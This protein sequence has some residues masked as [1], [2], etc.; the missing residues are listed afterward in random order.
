M[1][2]KNAALPIVFSDDQPV[3]ILHRVSSV[4]SLLKNLTGGDHV[5]PDST[6]S[7]DGDGVEGLAQVFG[8]I[9]FATTEA[10]KKMEG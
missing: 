5:K 10:I 3:D 9:H 2:N 1:I 6:L 4:V 8:F 7:L